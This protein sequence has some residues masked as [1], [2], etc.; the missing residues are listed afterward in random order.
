LP[1]LARVLAGQRLDELG[2]LVPAQD[3][4]QCQAELAAV[5]KELSTL[6]DDALYATWGRWILA[7]PDQRPIAPGL[8]ITVAEARARSD[9]LTKVSSGRQSAYTESAG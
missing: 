9:R 5:R 6:S 7:D 1:R 4:A 8:N 2:A 3:F